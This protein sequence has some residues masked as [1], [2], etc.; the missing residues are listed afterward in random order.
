M[1]KSF[2]VFLIIA[3]TLIGESITFSWRGFD[4]G[5]WTNRDDQNETSGGM[6]APYIDAGSSIWTRRVGRDSDKNWK[7]GPLKTK[8]IGKTE[9]YLMYHSWSASCELS[10]S[11]P[12]LTKGHW[13]GYA[14]VPNKD[15]DEGYK[16]KVD[17]V[18]NESFSRDDTDWFAHH[19]PDDTIDDCSAW[20]SIS[21]FDAA[22]NISYDSYSHVPF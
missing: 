12:A 20:A 9:Q 11:D 2:C 22:N 16:Y 1:K 3:L 19:D 6:L 13:H 21:M 4:N 7:N 10:N 18:V 15:P 17:G 5:R 14:D 8:S